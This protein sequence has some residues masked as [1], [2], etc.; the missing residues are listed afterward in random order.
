MFPLDHA[1]VRVPRSTRYQR[2]QNRESRQSGNA[3]TP[4]HNTTLT[5]QLGAV[6]FRAVLYSFFSFSTAQLSRLAVWGSSKG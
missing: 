6:L 3:G 5:L 4:V 1:F 2:V